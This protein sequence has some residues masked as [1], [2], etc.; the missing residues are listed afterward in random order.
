MHWARHAKHVARAILLGM[1][2][3]AAVAGSAAAESIVIQGS[4]AFS[5]LVLEPNQAAIEAASGVELTIIPNKSSLGLERL[6]EGNA[7]LA[8]L[9]DFIDVQAAPLRTKKP[10]LPF[11]KL[12]VFE[13]APSRAAFLVHPSNPVRSATPDQLRGLLTGDIANWR[14]LGG[15]DLPVRVAI[16]RE[17]GSTAMIERQFLGGRSLAGDTIFVPVG[18][19]TGKVVAQL[20]G[21]LAVTQAR[22]GPAYGLPEIKTT[23]TMDRQLSLVSLGEPTPAMIAVIEAV[24]RIANPD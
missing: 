19:Q 4:G 10:G 11:E 2:L 8:M 13:V 20:P 23:E 12:R 22:V 16:V 3:T 6:L 24:R 17:G 5:T 14:E 21:G 1:G 9:S 15:P 18:H 7:D